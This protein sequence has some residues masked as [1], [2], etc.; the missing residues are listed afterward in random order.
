ME[1]YR[2]MAKYMAISSRKDLETA[3]AGL[4][5]RYRNLAGNSAFAREIQEKG[6]TIYE[7][8]QACLAS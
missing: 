8:G 4:V 7:A 5:A 3:H 2:N 6:L 1:Q